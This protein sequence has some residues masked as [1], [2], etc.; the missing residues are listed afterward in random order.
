MQFP[1]PDQGFAADDDKISVISSVSDLGSVLEFNLD[2]FEKD[3][4]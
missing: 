3:L 1:L 2:D 4:S